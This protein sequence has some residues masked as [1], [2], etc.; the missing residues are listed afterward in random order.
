MVVSGGLGAMPTVC[1]PK[2]Y[3][4]GEPKL[5]AGPRDYIYRGDREKTTQKRSLFMPTKTSYAIKRPRN[6]VPTA[7]SLSAL[8]E[9]V[10]AIRRS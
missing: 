10:S 6:V 3:V 8:S 1:R 9:L 7:N 4:Y 5:P 2:A